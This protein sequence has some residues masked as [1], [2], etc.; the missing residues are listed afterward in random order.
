[1]R[2]RAVELELD[3]DAQI[4]ARRRRRPGC[5]SSAGP[6]RAARPSR[7][8]TASRRRSSCRRRAMPVSRRALGAAAGRLLLVEER[9]HLVGVEFLLLGLRLGGRLRDRLLGVLAVRRL[10]GLG[11]RRL[12]LCLGRRRLGRQLARRLRRVGSSAAIASRHGVGLDLLLGLRLRRRFRGRHRAPA[13]V[14]ARPPARA[15]FGS[16]GFGSGFGDRLRRRRPPR[17]SF[18]VDLGRRLLVGIDLVLADLLARR[19]PLSVFCV[20]IRAP[21]SR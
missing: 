17:L 21:A 15:L 20:G 1:M 11:L 16:T 18:G 3:R 4:A 5:S 19:A 7:F 10:G 13:S 9:R 12:R 14:R 6:G 2:A 8:A